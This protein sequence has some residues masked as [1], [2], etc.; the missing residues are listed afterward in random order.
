MK[1]L[2]QEIYSESWCL[3]DLINSFYNRKEK[4]N[5]DE[6]IDKISEQEHIIANLFAETYNI[7]EIEATHMMIIVGSYLNFIIGMR[8]KKALT[9][10][11]VKRIYNLF[12]Y[13]I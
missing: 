7:L 5:A 2:T 6:L 1:E 11:D 10:D 12:D 3:L 13:T 8:K 9:I 4:V